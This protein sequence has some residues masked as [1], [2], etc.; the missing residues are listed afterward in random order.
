MSADLDALDRG[1]IEVGLT[2]AEAMARV[3][4][5]EEI[6]EVLQAR[7]DRLFDMLGEAVEAAGLPVPQP[8]RPLRL[9]TS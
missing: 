3:D 1:L 2:A 4:S 5:Q 7:M 6:I 9:V 8:D